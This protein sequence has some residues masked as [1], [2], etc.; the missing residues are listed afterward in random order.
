MAA[1]IG[2]L[3]AELARYKGQ[4]P[5]GDSCGA[6]ASSGRDADTPDLVS[7]Q[8]LSRGAGFESHGSDGDGFGDGDEESASESSGARGTH[9]DEAL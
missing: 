4:Q 1:R 7:H 8:S 5:P 2:E 9:T 3:E 6:G